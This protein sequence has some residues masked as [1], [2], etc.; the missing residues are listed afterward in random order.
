MTATP[1]LVALILAVAVSAA[2]AQGGTAPGVI[3]GE[4]RVT[5][6]TGM[7]VAQVAPDET[8]LITSAITGRPSVG[9]PYVHIVRVDDSA[10]ITQKLTWSFGTAEAGEEGRL[11]AVWIPTKVGEYEA[12]VFV[13]ESIDDPV[14]LAPKSTVRITVTNATVRAIGE[15]VVPPAPSA[16]PVAPIPPVTALP[17]AGV[18]V[19]I[20]ERTGIAGCERDDE[21]YLPPRIEVSPG[22]AVTWENTDFAAHTVTAGAPGS[23]TGAMS[24]PA[25]RA[26][27]AGCVICFRVWCARCRF[28]VRARRAPAFQRAA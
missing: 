21:C 18:V 15:P 1:V 9:Q 6:A 27:C 8:V 20:P 23:A 4:P 28:F 24:S 16:L 13:W 22:T 25:A 5:D 11:S 14:A 2:H 3:I 26:P 12:T 10:G 19:V 7:P 17:A